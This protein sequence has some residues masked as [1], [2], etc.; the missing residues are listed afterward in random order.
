MNL[1]YGINQCSFK[2]AI[3]VILWNL[4]NA[5][6]ICNQQIYYPNNFHWNLLE[7]LHNAN[8]QINLT[9]NANNTIIELLMLGF[10]SPLIIPDVKSF[11]GFSY[12]VWG[13]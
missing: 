10:G 8:R 4:A 12:S 11:M 5:I 9:I 2:N 3:D 1:N 13:N 6:E 7:V